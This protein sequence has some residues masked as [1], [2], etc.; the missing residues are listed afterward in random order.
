MHRR[1]L[2]S[3]HVWRNETRCHENLYTTGPE[4]NKGK[5]D[6][7]PSTIDHFPITPLAWL[8]ASLPS[9]LPCSEAGVSRVIIINGR[10]ACLGS[11][12]VVVDLID[13]RLDMVLWA[14]GDQQSLLW[15]F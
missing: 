13:D 9:F 14:T 7:D 15:G 12:D 4:Q 2:L 10:K 3:Y 6:V 11:Q 8:A 5:R 1:V